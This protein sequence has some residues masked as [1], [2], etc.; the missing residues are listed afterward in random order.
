MEL[1]NKE[2]MVVEFISEAMEHFGDGFSDIDLDAITE[3]LKWS[4]ETA[5][6]VIG[7]LVKKEILFTLDVNGENKIYYL[8]KYSQNP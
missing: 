5:K 8:A 7:S 6:G 2:K 3:N 4:E 1:T